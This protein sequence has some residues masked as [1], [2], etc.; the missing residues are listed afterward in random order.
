MGRITLPMIHTDTFHRP[1]LLPRVISYLNVV[2]GAKYI[3]ATLGG[4][5][6]TFEILKGG[7]IVLGIDQDQEAIKFV[8]GKFDPDQI[9]TKFEID[10]EIFLEE[11]NFANLKSIAGKYGFEAVSGIIFDLGMS[12]Y[13]IDMSAKGFSFH[14]DEILD[15]R[16]GNEVRLKASDILNNFSE[17]RLY[18]IFSSFS[19]ELNSRAIAHAVFR[20]RTLKQNIVRTK[21]LVNIVNKVIGKYDP[22]VLARVFQALR[23]AVNNEIEILKTGLFEAVD[24]LASKGVVIVLSYHSLEDRTVKMFFK[25]KENE[26]CLRIITKHCIRPDR[27]EMSNNPR[28]RSARMRVAE[29]I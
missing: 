3:D 6:Y 13:Q 22:K 17:E 26:G 5:G 24:L 20:A 2:K 8:K 21:D 14:K 16:M 29:K 25:L 28:S 19:E 15:M 10:R 4:G 9:G 1:V 11:G 27:F 18:E 12:S 23:V 7:G